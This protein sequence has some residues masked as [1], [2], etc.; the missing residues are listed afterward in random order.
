MTTTSNSDSI[1]ALAWA[2]VDISA[3]GEFRP[4]C[5]YDGQLRDTSGKEVNVAEF[6][7]SEMVN[8][9]D[10]QQLRKQMLNG[11]KPTVCQ[12]CWVDE[13]HGRLSPRKV[14]NNSINLDIDEL[15]LKSEPLV[16]VSMALGNICNL[17]CRIC[18]PWASSV[19]ISDEI[20]RLGKAHST[21]EQIWLKQGA[22]PLAANDLWA[23]ISSTDS[24][25]LLNFYGGEPFM[26]PAHL[27]ILEKFCENNLNEKIYIR[28]VTNATVFPQKYLST[29]KKF[30]H[31][32][33]SFSIDDI[34]QRFEYQ[35]KN[36]IW[37]EMV[38]VVDQFLS[39]KNI[40]YSI[41]CTV[42]VYN[43]L[44]LEN[45]ISQFVQQWPGVQIN[46]SVLRKDEF[47]SILYAPVEFK[48]AVKQNLSGHTFPSYIA[49]QIDKIVDMMFA[50]DSNNWDDLKRE[51]NK[52]DQFRNEKL[53]DTHP[54]LYNY[55]LLL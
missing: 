3:K 25:K 21:T 53:Q 7:L 26:S 45:I 52:I 50:H 38:N 23:D 33:I 35:R 34:D 40:N 29:L 2:G 28:Y 11:E 46:L 27:Q 44:Y 13:Q 15:T 14:A 32:S 24:I 39:L 1:C 5:D 37:A 48:R 41:N 49:T 12:K 6:P 51:V 43:A 8:S 19:W 17:R 36:A 4:C 22:W 30:K 42:S 18:G 54:E 55:I 20:R 16:Q 10:I 9:H 31:I 47:N